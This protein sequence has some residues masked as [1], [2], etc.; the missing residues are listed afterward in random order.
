MSALERLERLVLQLSPDDLAKFR[1]W[2]VE[3]DHQLWDEQIEADVA[4]GRFDHI[5]AETTG[6]V[7]ARKMPTD[8]DSVVKRDIQE[9]LN[10]LKAGRVVGPF[11]EVEELKRHLAARR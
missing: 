4:T 11:R 5:V 7:K 3:L 2:F 6:E 9:G 10:D 8:M 1:A